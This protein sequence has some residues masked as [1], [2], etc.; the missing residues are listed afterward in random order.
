MCTIHLPLAYLR[1]S[2]GALDDRGAE[3]DASRPGEEE[4]EEASLLPVFA[5]KSSCG[6]WW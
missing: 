4:D 3:A 2:H 1:I 5:L 6:G